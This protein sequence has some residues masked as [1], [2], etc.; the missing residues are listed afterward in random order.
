[1]SNP[2]GHDGPGLISGDI[3]TPLQVHPGDTFTLTVNGIGVVLDTGQGSDPPPARTATITIAGGAQ[4][5]GDIHFGS[6]STA[7][8]WPTSLPVTVTG[9]P[10][11]TIDIR[12]SQAERIFG[13][14]P[15]PR[16]YD[17]NCQTAPDDG[18][19]VSI[20]IVAP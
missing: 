13:P 4:P 2:V 19:L 17:L 20:A 3:D 9:Q 7:A 8:V 10:G 16:S 12:V 14:F 5:S 6:G 1:M 11:E 18:E 15:S